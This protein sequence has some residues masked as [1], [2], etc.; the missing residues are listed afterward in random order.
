LLFNRL[1]TFT[2]LSEQER[3]C[4]G[5]LGGTIHQYAARS[6]IR[7]Q[8]DP[9]DEIYALQ[10][11]W[12][13]GSFD[14]KDGRRQTV[15]VHL[16]GDMLGAP[17]LAM[18][19]AGETLTSITPVALRAIRLSSLT[20]LFQDHPRLTAALFLCAQQER[21]FLMERLASIGQSR[22]ISRFAA[23]LLDLADR[24]SMGL[25][26]RLTSFE[27]PLTQQEMAEILGITTVHM[28]RIG[29]QLIRTS[30]IQRD[31]RLLTLLDTAELA[32]LSCMPARNWVHRPAWLNALAPA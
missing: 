25:A 9:V 21:F 14:L 17:S 20:T 2:E 15:K 11:G 1:E 24:L 23:L 5:R 18:E 32:K 12:V 19:R 13:T 4:L 7:R 27:L 6:V 28:N 10:S 8:G 31:H 30:I 22:A 29:Q 16:P 3:I 26:D